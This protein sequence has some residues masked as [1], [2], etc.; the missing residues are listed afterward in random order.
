[1]I[2]VDAQPKP[3]TFEKKVRQKGLA[4]L[5]KN[6]IALDQPLPPGTNIKP[7]WRDCLD[8]MHA[9]Y[10]GCCAYLAV[11]FERATGGGS[12]DHFIA[13]SQRADLA[14]EWSNYRLSCSKMNSRKRDSADVLDP[15]EVETGWF[16]LELVSGRIFPN[17]KLQGKQQKAVKATIDRLGLDGAGNREMRARHYQQYL[18]NQYPAIFLKKQSPFVW[19][20][21]KR[22][23]LL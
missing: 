21:A 10:N 9:S 5:R 22:R 6:K 23:G 20:E 19:M 8:D 7:Y 11:F 12:V 13:K 2:Y 15:F 1:M 17:P 18:D 4:W 14:Y 16:H 3:D